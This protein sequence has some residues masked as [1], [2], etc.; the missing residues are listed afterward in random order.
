MISTLIL[1]KIVNQI[2]KSNILKTIHT[3]E[4]RPTPFKDQSDHLKYNPFLLKTIHIFR[5]MTYTIWG[6][7]HTISCTINTIR[8]TTHTI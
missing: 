7:I 1:L 2:V 5:S 8:S 6:T 3:F 4:V